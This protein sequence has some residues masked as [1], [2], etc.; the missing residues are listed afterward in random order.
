M[1]PSSGRNVQIMAASPPGPSG[2][3]SLAMSELPA[4]EGR[5]PCEETRFSVSLSRS[6]TGAGGHGLLFMH[7]VHTVRGRAEDDVEAKLLV[8][9]PW[10][11]LRD[12][13]FNDVPKDGRE[14]ELTLYMEDTMWPYEDKLGEYI[15]R[16]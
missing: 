1:P 16:S 5:Y 13:D 6:N 10:S 3:S 4:C 7:E 12:V 15:D 8:P 11:P 14:H 2:T 9:L